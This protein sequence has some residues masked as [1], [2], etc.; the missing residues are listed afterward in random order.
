VSIHTP[1]TYDD[2]ADWETPARVRAGT[3]MIPIGTK[4]GRLTVVRHVRSPLDKR[5]R[6]VCVCDCGDYTAPTTGCLLSG[7]TVSCGCRLRAIRRHGTRLRHGMSHTTEHNIWLGMKNRCQ[8]QTHQGYRHYG[9]RGVKVCERWLNSFEAFYADMGPRPSPRHSIDRIDN[10]GDY[11][12]SNCR[13]ATR[14][15]QAS[16]RRA[17][18]AA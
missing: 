1:G 16:N 13:W 5:L 3:T 15:E 12:P 2:F 14:E 11:E 10:N 4:I 17:R 7:G 18:R 9:G 8:N 6:W